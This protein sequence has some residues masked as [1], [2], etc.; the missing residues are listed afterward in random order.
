M[1]NQDVE[2]NVLG[3]HCINKALKEKL[4]TLKVFNNIDR[5]CSINC[6]Y[7]Y[8]PGTMLNPPQAPHHLS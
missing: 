4:N 8:T 7:Y 2:L 1:K 6:N 5:N 3:R